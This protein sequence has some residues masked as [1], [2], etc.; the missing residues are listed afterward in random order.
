M[1]IDDG[2]DSDDE[3]YDYEPEEFPD[4]SDSWYWEAVQ[5]GKV[6]S[7]LEQDIRNPATRPL[8][9]F[10][11]ETKQMAFKV[12]NENFQ[13]LEEVGLESFWKK[14]GRFGFLTPESYMAIHAKYNPTGKLFVTTMISIADG[15][16]VITKDRSELSGPTMLSF[17][18][19]LAGV[20]ARAQEETEDLYGPTA[21]LEFVSIERIDNPK[22]IR[23][24]V[25]AREDLFRSGEKGSI[26]QEFKVEKSSTPFA[27]EDGRNA[28]LAL[29]G[30]L[31][32][33]TIV[34]MIYTY[35]NRF[36]AAA[37]S[38]IHVQFDKLNDPTSAK[39]FL[40]FEW[41]TDTTISHTFDWG[42]SNKGGLEEEE[43]ERE[44]EEDQ[45]SQE[46]ITEEDP[47]KLEPLPPDANVL[48]IESAESSVANGPVL[49]PLLPDIDRTTYK[50]PHRPTFKVIHS[51]YQATDRETNIYI[52]ACSQQEGEL[53]FL[54]FANK[55]HDT[56]VNVAQ[57]NKVLA[58]IL[59]AVW[60]HETRPDAQING[61]AFGNLSPLTQDSLN[62]AFEQ[63]KIYSISDVQTVHSSHREFSK[64]VATLLQTREGKALRIFLQKYG[65]GLGNLQLDT[66]QYG[67]FTT[68]EGSFIYATFI[69]SSTSR[70]ARNAKVRQTPYFYIRRMLHSGSDSYVE[71][72]RDT[73]EHLEYISEVIRGVREV[74]P[75]A[76][77]STTSLLEK[78]SFEADK[79][80]RSGRKEPLKFISPAKDHLLAFH[81]V[82]PEMFPIVFW[83]HKG[84]TVHMPHREINRDPS[85]F[86]NIAYRGINIGP[87]GRIDKNNGYELAAYWYHMHLVVLKIP[88]EGTHQNSPPLEDILFAAWVGVY[89]KHETSELPPPQGRLLYRKISNGAPVGIVSFLDLTKETRALVRV[90]FR[91][92]KTP[93]SSAICLRD[94][95]SLIF[96]TRSFVRGRMSLKTIEDKRKVSVAR[97]YWLTLLATPEVKAVLRMFSK[98]RYQLSEANAVDRI[99]LRWRVESNDD[100]PEIIVTSMKWKLSIKTRGK[101]RKGFRELAYSEDPVAR[102]L[103]FRGVRNML[104]TA[105]LA[106]INVKPQ[107]EPAITDAE[108]SI[109]FSPNRVTGIPRLVARSLVQLKIEFPSSRKLTFKSAT[110]VA[111]LEATASSRT[112]SVTSKLIVSGKNQHIIVPEPLP[113]AELDGSASFKRMGQI[114]A[115]IW[116]ISR[117]YEP[118]A[119]NSVSEGKRTWARSKIS[120][121]IVTFLQLTS[122]SED[123]VFDAILT[124][125]GITETPS[126]HISGFIMDTFKVKYNGDLVEMAERARPEAFY[127]LLGLKEVTA[128]S[129]ML[130]NYPVTVINNR[131]VAFSVNGTRGNLHLNVYLGNQDTRAVYSL[132][133]ESDGPDGPDG[134][135]G[136]DRTDESDESDGS[137]ED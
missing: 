8:E 50:S 13:L 114:F 130:E 37:L 2:D 47:P 19:L 69:S 80:R 35:P 34:R 127:R 136:T 60:I 49:H 97:L 46:N 27:D 116:W 85:V 56:T 26:T 20:W 28:W 72:L 76:Y 118:D 131:V 109:Q 59:Y 128:I 107:D 14:I 38:S 62:R 137:E 52:V 108:Y 9:D 55:D 133:F 70:A 51:K 32:I 16:M 100:Y 42:G 6:N 88:S 58:D 98:Y 125:L 111:Y 86:D 36:H 119:Q 5:D 79:Y 105:H 22:T 63:A 12:N 15:H 120:L 23:Q 110:N 93:K 113:E 31:D 81:K 106:F 11:I 102:K 4:E 71:G 25:R 132:D 57:T 94:T 92:T 122:E 43:L 129:S 7:D 39:V 66:I 83:Y 54:G 115:K 89:G 123:Q 82:D 74:E 10:S 48:I 101:G 124:S 1:D 126:G 68:Q 17:S 135:D 117:P 84:A 87:K 24:M 96:S 77:P 33:N 29:R 65:D 73:A 61:M 78:F 18:N 21:R 103:R 40:E 104:L 121:K 112:K 91:A 95:T 3:M 53:A 44:Q 64:I 45:E 75:L 30:T 41:P 99:C 134:T 90:I 67:K